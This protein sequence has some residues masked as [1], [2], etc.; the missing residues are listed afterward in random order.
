MTQQPIECQAAIDAVKELLNTHL[1][2]AEDSADEDGKFSLG[3]RVTFDRSHSP[4]KLKVTCRVSKITT[5]E[6]ECAIDDPN[7]AKLPL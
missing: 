1:Q 5:D 2:E 6:I 3:F 7:Q 4:T